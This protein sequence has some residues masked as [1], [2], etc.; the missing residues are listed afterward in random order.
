MRASGPK[1]PA[2]VSVQVAQGAKCYLVVRQLPGG[3]AVGV[4]VVLFSM[5]KEGDG[6]L[7]DGDVGLRGRFRSTGDQLA[8]A[9]LPF[10]EH[11]GIG[12]PAV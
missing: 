2:G 5:G 7:V 10:G 3:C 8:A 9:G 12:G 1:L 4:A 6:Q 11:A